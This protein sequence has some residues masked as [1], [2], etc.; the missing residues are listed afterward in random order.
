MFPPPPP[1]LSHSA[2]SPTLSLTPYTHHTHNDTHAHSA[3]ETLQ[4]SAANRV[5]YLAIPP[6][7][8]VDVASN[9]RTHLMADSLG[10][11]RLVVEKVRDGVSA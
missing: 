2:P 10:W 11:S 3:R 7:L 6:S 8:F 1:P 9:V 5:Y 4:S